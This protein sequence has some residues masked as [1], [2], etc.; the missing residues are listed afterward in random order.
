[1]YSTRERRGQREGGKE[2]WRGGKME[3]EREYTVTPMIWI[4]K[5]GIA[6]G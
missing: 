1:M 3:G 4:W 2:G 5:D 6:N